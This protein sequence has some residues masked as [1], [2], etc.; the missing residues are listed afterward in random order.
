M[1][2]KLID[3]LLFD[4]NENTNIFNINNKI[5]ININKI[6]LDNEYYLLNFAGDIFLS[7]QWNC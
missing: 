3:N 2:I 7:K 6:R 5:A 4:E 1:L